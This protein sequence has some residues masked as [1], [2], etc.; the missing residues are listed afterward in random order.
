MEQ[1]VFLVLR[2]LPLKR[3]GRRRTGRNRADGLQQGIMEA[4]L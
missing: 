2:N 3:L 4:T 1:F